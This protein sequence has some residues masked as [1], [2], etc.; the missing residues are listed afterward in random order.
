MGNI[1]INTIIPVFTAFGG[2]LLTFWFREKQETLSALRAI[3]TEL[4]HNDDLGESTL[5]DLFSERPAGYDKLSKLDTVPLQTSAFE[6]FVN[7]GVAVKIS[8]DIEDS[9]WYHYLVVRSINRDISRR[10]DA[11]DQTEISRIDDEILNGI[12]YLSGADRLEVMKA[13][14]RGNRSVE[15]EITEKLESQKNLEDGGWGDVTKHTFD[16]IEDTLEKEIR[17]RHP[18]PVFILKLAGR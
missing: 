2:V 11:S 5:H 18:A 3:K 4:K 8:D 15:Q 16:A 9:I 10:L 13:N 14:I 6:H 17:A 1:A 12:L 7:S